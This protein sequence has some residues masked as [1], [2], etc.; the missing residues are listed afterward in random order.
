MPPVSFHSVS[1]HYC[2]SEREVNWTNVG[3]GRV[4]WRPEYEANSTSTCSARTNA[5]DLLFSFSLLEAT[6]SLLED[7]LLERHVGV[8]YNIYTMTDLM[9]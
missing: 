5:I 8:C 2:L 7:V 1:A 4:V 3:G 9:V 6:N